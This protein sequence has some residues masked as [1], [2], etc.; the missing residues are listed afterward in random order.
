[1]VSL[2]MVKGQVVPHESI[3]KVIAGAEGQKEARADDAAL[4]G[5]VRQPLSTVGQASVPRS[6]DRVTP[7]PGEQTL[8]HDG[9]GRLSNNRRPHLPSGR[10]CRSQGR[11]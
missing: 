6:N 7:T 4:M 11:V 10:R 1:M 5:P 2:T 3:G 8:G 9:L